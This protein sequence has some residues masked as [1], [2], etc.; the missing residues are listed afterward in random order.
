MPAHVTLRAA[1]GIPSLRS[2]RVFPAVREALAAGSREKFRVVHWSVQRDHLHL[3]VEAADTRAFRSGCQG[4]AVRIAKAVNRRLGRHGAVWGDRYH[5]RSL[6]TPR[7]VRTAL[8]YVLANWRK[9]VRGARGWDPRSSAAWFDGWRTAP[10]PPA[11]P[12]PVVPART[13]LARVGWR[14]HGLVRSSEAPS[15]SGL[16]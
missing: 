12:P 6:S 10:R 7:A 1:D 16:V 11:G 5:A 3:L 13:W 15:R 2:E 4:L 9:H 8:V 14:R